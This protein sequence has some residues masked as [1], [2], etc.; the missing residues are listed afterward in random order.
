MPSSETI[1]QS[2]DALF[3]AGQL[4]AAVAAQTEEVKRHPAEPDGRLFLFELL[5]FSGDLDRAS[6]QLEAVDYHDMPRDAAVAIYR[7]LL[8][9]E[10]S[11][12]NV[13]QEGETPRYLMDPPA[14]VEMRLDA[15]RHWQAGESDAAKRL[16]AEAADQMPTL[17][18]TLNEREFSLLVDC[19][20]RF[21]TIL[22]VMSITGAYFW[23]PLE[24]VALLEVDEP[25]YP[26]DLLWLPAELELIDGQTGH[27]YL[28]TLYP[29]TCRQADD[30]LKLGRQTDWSLSDAE[31]VRGWGQ[32][33][34]LCDDDAVGLLEWRRLELG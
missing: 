14:H 19:D 27:V 15:L 22:E 32:R 1:Q 16:L 12:H 3:K 7:R 9:A 8:D 13:F 2:A 11:R 34:Y 30:M 18:G 31:P 29:G 17:K 26:R 28:P 25:Q 33:M 4:T 21:G 6:K 24:T 5:A 20:D 23:V 10:R